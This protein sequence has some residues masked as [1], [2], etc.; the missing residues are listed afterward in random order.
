MQLVKMTYIF[1]KEQLRAP[2]NVIWIVSSPV[3]LFFFLHYKDIKIHSGD[4]AW[5]NS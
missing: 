1:L 5:L 3:V 4:K 2:F